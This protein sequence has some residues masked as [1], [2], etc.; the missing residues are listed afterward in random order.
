[1]TATDQR[2]DL[3]R[4]TTGIAELD[5]ILGGG[6]PTGS[7]IVLAGPPG[8]GK[9]ILAQQ[10]A[11]ANASEE[12]PALYY[13][14]LS[15]S[16]TKIL[17]HLEPF[18][19]FDPEALG[20]AVRFLHVTELI[21]GADESERGLGPLFDE[22]IDAAFDR[23]PS[24][25]VLDSAKALH[26]FGDDARL[27]E[28]VFD[29][30]SKVSHTG[31]VLL[32]VGEY[33]ERE[34]E[35][36]PEF[37]VADGILELAHD[38]GGA[39]D[40]RFLRVRKMRGAATL[41]GRH[42]FRI[43]A[44][45]HSVYP[46]IES[47]APRSPAVGGPRRRFGAEFLDEMTA[48]GL[49][50][51]EA[52]L[53]MGPSGAGKTV[54]AIEFVNAGLE[55][56]ERCLYISF[57]ES[58]AQITNKA[59]TFGW[60]LAGAHEAGRLHLWHIPPVELDIDELAHRV[61]RLVESTGID[62]VVF[63][64]LGEIVPVA[65]EQGRFPGYLWALATTVTATGA[66]LVFTQETAALGPHEERFAKLSYLFH[67]VLVLRY[68]EHGSSV[69]RGLLILKMR[70]SD[71]HKRLV[72]FAIGASGFEITGEVAAAQGL[73]GGSSLSAQEIVEIERR[74]AED[75]TGQTPGEEDDEPGGAAES[76]AGDGPPGAS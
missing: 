8:T 16:Q 72:A 41:M 12:R 13:T 27:R 69:A 3:G 65:Q 60:D 36:A 52:T 6:L 66:S 63:D 48:G 43:S 15:E 17:R 67:N 5:D 14:T 61:R 29:L 19:F 39:V 42:G 37:A 71:H 62:R 54:L 21:Q 46:R 24:L 45:G 7:L 68:M 35:E 2:R 56:G 33:T 18:A 51:G 50:R 11:F 64:S 4:L 9:T 26:A 57:E 75:R 70:E 1:M 25:I 23:E 59:T 49:P 44:D 73:L 10:M 31:A 20:S 55:D 32:L 47:I 76:P 58:T 34:I 40:R 22:I 53:L 28:A 74:R 30:A 38:V